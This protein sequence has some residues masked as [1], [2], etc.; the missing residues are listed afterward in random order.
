MGLFFEYLF[1]NPAMYLSW[2]TVIVFSICVHEY[3]HAITALR[4]GDDTAARAGHLTLN[5]L[6]QMGPVSLVVLLLVGIAWGSVPIRPE[7]LRGRRDGAWV[8]FAG[9]LSNLALA[10]I[11]VLLA[12]ALAS[13][14]PTA[15][16]AI[17]VLLLAARA[18]MVLFLFNMLPIPMLDGWKVYAAWIPG[19]GRIPDE[20]LGNVSWML[21]LVVWMTPA[22]T[23]IWRGADTAVFTAMAF[24]GQIFG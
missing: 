11:S 22:F 6:V 15:E 2:V 16:A 21:I 3:A 13:W 17:G 20:H 18:N 5:P 10:A 4:L 1:S 8:A 19:M 23:M 7:A 12:T 9:P 14:A 24:L